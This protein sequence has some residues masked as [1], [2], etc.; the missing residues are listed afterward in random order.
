MATMPDHS[1]PPGP[2]IPSPE[3]VPGPAPDS[4]APEADR[5]ELRVHGVS[6]GRPKELL[7]VE[8]A[9]RVGGDRMAGF[10]R[11]RREPDTETVPGMRRDIFAWGNLTSGNASR[12]FWLLLLPFM[13]V[14]MAYWMRPGR[15]DRG[16]RGLRRVANNLYGAGVRVL[17]LALTVLIVLAAA[18]IRRELVAWPCPAQAEERVRA[19]PR[20]AAPAAPGR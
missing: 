20:A 12:A 9:V 10:F 7:D 17:A 3:P 5:V 15:V 8:P 18:G 6:G 14:N 16:P 11:W 1:V 2:R 19:G 4:P 13:L